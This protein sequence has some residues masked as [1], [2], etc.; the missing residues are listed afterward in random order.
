MAVPVKCW[1][2]CQIKGLEQRLKR[3]EQHHGA[4][5][6]ADSSAVDASLRRGPEEES[7]RC[8]AGIAASTSILPDIEGPVLFSQ[9]PAKSHENCENQ[10][11]G[12]AS[13]S[14]PGESCAFAH[15]T[16]TMDLIERLRKRSQEVLK[17]LQESQASA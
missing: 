9:H 11:I 6:S 15:S 14:H 8:S 12:P 5:F 7:F 4:A 17:Y 13:S 1:V 2:S 10:Q 16:S 3:L